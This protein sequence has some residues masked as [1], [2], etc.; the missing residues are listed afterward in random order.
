[1][2]QQQKLK[3]E[4]NKDSYL[5]TRMLWNAA[6]YAKSYIVSEEEAEEYPEQYKLSDKERRKIIKLIDLILMLNIDWV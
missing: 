5:I 4:E 6:S 3:Q 2:E 1:M